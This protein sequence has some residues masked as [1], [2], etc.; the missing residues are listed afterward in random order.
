MNSAQA[1]SLARAASAQGVVQCHVLFRPLKSFG[2]NR[3]SYGEAVADESICGGIGPLCS[4]GTD[5]VLWPDDRLGFVGDCYTAR[6]M[7][8]QEA[9]D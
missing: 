2:E 7:A 1:A 6:N 9:A 3:L 4:R 5:L 8:Q